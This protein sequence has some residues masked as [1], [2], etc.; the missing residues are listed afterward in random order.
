M[1]KPGTL[2]GFVPLNWSIQC[3]GA[4]QQ[5]PSWNRRQAV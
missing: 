4:Q 1:N 3:G 2:V 5:T